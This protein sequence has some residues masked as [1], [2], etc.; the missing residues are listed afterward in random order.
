MAKNKI[1][2]HLVIGY[3]SLEESFNTALEYINHGVEILELQIP[4]SHP[5]ADG[6]V[7]TQANQV[8]IEQNHVT[9]D[10]CFNQISDLLKLHPTQKVV[11]MTYLNKVFSYGIENYINKIA[12]LNIS[13]VII[14]DLPFDSEIAN[15]FHKSKVNLVPV[16]AANI[17]QERLLKALS[18][19]SNY[20]YLMSSYQITG[21]K[22]NL[23]PDSKNLIQ[24]IKENTTA[25]IGI[26]FG[27]NSNEDVEEV[28]KHVDFAII[29]SSLI[30]AKNMNNLN[31]KLVGLLN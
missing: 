25:Q 16:M 12:A 22:F 11:P 18:H 24:T 20:I 15:S 3:P 13:D 14:P 30:N 23:H 1:M 29:G 17:S 31:D 6:T 27:I 7:I 28:L 19:P 10:A 2:G 26:G 4:F 21:Q 9:I 5:T 8:A